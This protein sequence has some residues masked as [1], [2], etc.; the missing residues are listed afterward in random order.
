MQ[1]V[2]AKMRYFV[3]QGAY[4]VYDFDQRFEGSE[5]GA[6]ISLRLCGYPGQEFNDDGYWITL[7]NILVQPIE[8][9]V[10]SARFRE[11]V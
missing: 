2:H 6:E 7:C 9:E 4:H 1:E 3:F 5:F 8:C 10:C 11:I